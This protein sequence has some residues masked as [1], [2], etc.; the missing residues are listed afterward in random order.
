MRRRLIQSHV[1]RDSKVYAACAF[2]LQ[3]WMLLNEYKPV[4][5]QMVMATLKMSLRLLM[6]ETLS[7][8][9][10][11]EFL[12]VIFC[13]LLLT[14]DGDIN[15]EVVRCGFFAPSVSALLANASGGCHALGI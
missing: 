12:P 4:T 1:K 5:I 10:M 13:L 9:F 15:V 8:S 14:E 11:A 7:N 2:V 3:Q 6:M